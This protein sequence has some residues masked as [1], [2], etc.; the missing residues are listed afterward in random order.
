MAKEKKVVSEKETT[1]EVKTVK[2]EE[3]KKEQLKKAKKIEKA[4]I[5]KEKEKVEKEIDALVEKRKATKDKAEKKALKAEIK[6]LQYKRSQIGKR[7]TFLGD[8]KKE[9]RLVRWPSKGEI[10][11]Y[12]IACLLFVVLFGLFFFGID[13]LFALISE[14]VRDM[15]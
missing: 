9:M 3:S 7:D 12:S 1:K 2:K 6:E 5:L 15:I 13:A 14:L 4:A 10:V 11:K 8:V